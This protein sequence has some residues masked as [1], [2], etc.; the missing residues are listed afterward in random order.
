MK[1]KIISLFVFAI[2]LSAPLAMQKAVGQI[3]FIN[4]LDEDG[5]LRQPSENPNL[6]GIPQLGENYDQYA[7]LGGC[8][9]LLGLG[10]AYLLFKRRKD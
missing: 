5:Y 3:I 4:E 6:P 1:K 2:L 8:G 9:C 7:P 10:G